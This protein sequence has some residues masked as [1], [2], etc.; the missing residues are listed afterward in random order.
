MFSTA[1]SRAAERA[2]R[3]AK[4]EAFKEQLAQMA[5][6]ADPG[7]R[8]PEVEARRQAWEQA[9][10][11]PTDT[12]SVR[13]GKHNCAQPRSIHD[14]GEHVYEDCTGVASKYERVQVYHKIRRV[15]VLKVGYCRQNTCECCGPAT[16]AR[17]GKGGNFCACRAVVDNL[18]RRCWID[19]YM[20]KDVEKDQYYGPL[21]GPPEG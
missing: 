18:C 3:Q 12:E 5:A 8:A 6:A 1:A 4:I 20:G 19:R 21:D 7:V 9:A 16:P 15:D 13:W 14:F 11:E 2:A 17:G 10:R